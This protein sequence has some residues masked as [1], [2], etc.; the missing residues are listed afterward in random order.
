MTKNVVITDIIIHYCTKEIRRCNDLDELLLIFMTDLYQSL[1]ILL[2]H[3]LCKYFKPFI[4]INIKI[5]FE[6][7]IVL[8]LYKLAKKYIFEQ[9]ACV[10]KQD[11]I[12]ILISLLISK[13]Q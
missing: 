2:L 4:P 8:Q 3:F 6:L 9:W 12:R 1:N 10:F 11:M 7:Y 5:L 13:T